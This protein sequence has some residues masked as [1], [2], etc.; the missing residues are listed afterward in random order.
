MSNPKLTTLDS[1]YIP[2]KERTKSMNWFLQHFDLIVE[3][4]HLK[5]GSTELFFLETMDETTT[6]FTT[7]AWQQEEKHYE[8][9]AFCFRT[10]NLRQ[11]HEKLINGNVRVTEVISHSWFEEFDFYDLDNNKFKVW[12]PSEA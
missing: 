4:D 6:N 1:I 7:S 10:E 8:M 5:I 3:G 2:V 12:R 9:P 11:L